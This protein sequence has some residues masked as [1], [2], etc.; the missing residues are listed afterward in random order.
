[1]PTKTFDSLPAQA[2]GEERKGLWK[3]NDGT[4]NTGARFHFC[5]FVPACAIPVLFFVPGSRTC[6]AI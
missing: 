5:A 1:M 2:D 4:Q 6:I 3:S